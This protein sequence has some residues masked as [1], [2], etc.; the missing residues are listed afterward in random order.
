MYCS[1]KRYRLV[2]S[3]ILALL[4]FCMSA[5]ANPVISNVSVTPLAFD[6]Y[7]GKTLLSAKVVS[8]PAS[9]SIN[10]VLSTV[11][12]NGALYTTG[13]MTAGANG[14]YTISYTLP[15]NSSTTAK[16]S[17][18]FSIDASDT[19]GNTSTSAL[20]GPVTVDFDGQ[21]PIITNVSV[22]P[23][24]FDVHGGVVTL[25]ATVTDKGGNNLGINSV[26]S[27]VYLNGNYYTSAYMNAGANDS[28]AINYTLPQN[29]STTAK[30]VYTFT[31]D[32]S[33]VVGNKSP[34]SALVG[35]VTVDFDGQAPII[36]NVVVTPPA[37]DV[38][39]GVVTL[40]A[41]VTDKGG[42]NLGINSVLSTVY[43]NGNYY[44]DAY[45]TAVAG[46]GYSINYTLPQNSSTTAKKVYT[47]TVDASDVV[48]NKSPTSALVGPVTVDFDGQAPIISNIAVTPTTLNAR[49]GIVTL[50]ATVTDKG[51][52]N[53][54][55][56][57]VLSTVYLNGNYYT[58]AYMTAGAND[59]Y[60]VNYTLPKNPS[61]D[62][63]MVWTF[64]IAATDVV[65]NSTTSSTVTVIESPPA[66]LAPIAN[67]DSK[68]TI[69]N[70][71]V[72]I[73][74][75]A[76]DTDPNMPPIPFAIVSFTQPTHGAA[77]K[78][79]DNTFT[80]TPA[81][82]YA[83]HDSF[84]Y[85]I[86][87]DNFS[88]T[89]QVMIWARGLTTVAGTI[90]LQDTLLQAQPVILQ[91]RSTDDGFSATVTLTPD[92]TGQFTA[93][94]VPE[95]TYDLAIKGSK[96]LQRVV[97][98]DA[99]NGPVS[100]VRASL[101]GGDANN[102]NSVDSTDFGLLI[103]TYNSNINLVGSGYDVHEDFNDD[104]SVDSTDFGI[105]IGNYNQRGDY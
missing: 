55:I 80:Y 45:M 13:Y 43:L 78:N 87:N 50:S 104:G 23:L 56:Y 54:G 65:G 93:A 57:R 91:F 77:V 31:V 82:D 17:Y 9:V 21:A 16:K 44:T 3:F 39:G 10:R 22:T 1:I 74:A 59:S 48:G 58:D 61:A 8:N 95:G 98:I 52:N 96:W 105:L 75:L 47:F 18:T 24:V 90:T 81:T 84:S 103:G 70:T 6:V 51:G 36:T 63:N 46:D 60:T 97:A 28:Y 86:S 66:K 49:G 25:S 92:S 99:T 11:Y 7:G 101:P 2:S 83:G 76:N 69:L 68:S 38:H 40:S 5:L 15:Q 30:K 64:K 73:N 33:D 102:D 89:A 37:F 88:A 29:S 27:T 79:A 4:A 62:A 12:L 100:G 34:T 19:A 20:V 14:A 71:P 72:T 41:T 35:P 26:L 53:L 32:A 85:T 67:N 42:N 94:K